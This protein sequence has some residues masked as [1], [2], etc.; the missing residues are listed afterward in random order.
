MKKRGKREWLLKL[1]YRITFKF[2][3]NT[4]LEKEGPL[5]CSGLWKSMFREMPG[6]YASP[7]SD[8]ARLSR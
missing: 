7:K 3:I 5:L 4:K 2:E 6:P 1:T 8:K